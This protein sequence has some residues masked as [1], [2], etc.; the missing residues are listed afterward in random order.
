MKRAVPRKR[1]L[2]RGLWRI[3]ATLAVTLLAPVNI[4]W[5]QPEATRP[6]AVPDRSAAVPGRVGAPE[7]LC[8]QLML[9]PADIPLRDSGVDQVH[10]ACGQRTVRVQSRGSLGHDEADVHRTATGSV[11]VALRVQESPGYEWELSVRLA[12]YHHVRN[13]PKARDKVAFGPVFL[14]TARLFSGRL[15]GM[16]AVYSPSVR[17]SVPMTN[18][19]HD[20]ATASASPAFAATVEVADKL[21]VHG[22]VAVLL[23]GA[24]ATDDPD[25]RVAFAVATDAAYLLTGSF[26]VTAGSQ[27]QTGWYG[28]GLDHLVVRSAIRVRLARGYRI[29][30]AASVPLAGAERTDWQ[31]Q[32]SLVRDL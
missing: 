3:V 21:L 26:A 5:A 14:G 32:L 15:L 12:D 17:L 13:D 11:F 7:A 1:A 24:L 29:D 22:R 28:V 25:G 23:W 16:R 18:T 6:L 31:A 30:L 27:V 10:S 8:Y 2:G 20:V 4:L 19:G 9:E